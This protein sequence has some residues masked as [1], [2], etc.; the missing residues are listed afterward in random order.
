[1]SFGLVNQ[2]AVK[3]PTSNHLS[4]KT[5]LTIVEIFLKEEEVSYL[6]HENF[7]TSALR[8]QDPLFS[9]EKNSKEKN[10]NVAC[11]KLDHVGALTH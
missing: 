1:M 2:L 11:A 4:L 8:P 9:P 7:L 3:Y 6:I 10:R 5:L